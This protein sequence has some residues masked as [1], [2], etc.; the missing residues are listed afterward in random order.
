MREHA[1]DA[2]GECCVQV[3][4]MPHSAGGIGTVYRVVAR[5]EGAWSHVDDREDVLPQRPA[6]RKRQAVAAGIGA[7][8]S[9]TLVLLSMRPAELGADCGAHSAGAG[10]GEQWSAGKWC[11]GAAEEGAR[12]GRW[13][14]GRREAPADRIGGERR[15]APERAR[16]TSGWAPLCS[17]A[18]W[19]RLGR[20]L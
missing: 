15:E 18:G 5:S 19:E 11:G 17:R 16:R 20:V 3:F 8:M 12:R 10:V 9:M 13:C 1:P 6:V 7:A 14:T 4:Q 2:T